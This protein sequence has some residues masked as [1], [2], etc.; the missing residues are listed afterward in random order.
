MRQSIDSSRGEQ[1]QVFELEGLVRQLSHGQG[2]VPGARPPPF[3]ASALARSFPSALHPPLEEFERRRRMPGNIG[4]VGTLLDTLPQSASC[5]SPLSEFS[6]SLDHDP[7]HGPLAFD[8]E[9]STLYER[10]AS[11]LY[12][13]S[14]GLY[15]V[16]GASR[17]SSMGETLPAWGSVN[18]PRQ[19]NIAMAARPS[20]DALDGR[21]AVGATGQPP[22]HVDDPLGAPSLARAKLHAEQLLPHLPHRRAAA[23]AHPCP[24][25]GPGDPGH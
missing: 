12:D 15:K 11:G 6:R 13:R 4:S 9:R 5:R 16:P 17:Q 8:L 18:K 25:H 22:S 3:R 1:E 20:F 2:D 21:A 14:S 19:Q 24:H 23:R 10:R 7:S